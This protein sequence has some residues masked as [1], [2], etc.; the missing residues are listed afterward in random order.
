MASIH[1]H[2]QA[3]HLGAR[4]SL[5]YA[6][7]KKRFKYHEELYSLSIFSNERQDFVLS[8]DESAFVAQNVR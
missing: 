3:K 5:P 7:G 8:I 1:L 4:I 6:T 2:T